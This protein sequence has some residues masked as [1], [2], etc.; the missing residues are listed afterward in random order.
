MQA[1][2]RI[3]ALVERSPEDEDVLWALCNAM[4]WPFRG[5]PYTMGGPDDDVQDRITAISP[6][7]VAAR[8][9]RAPRELVF[10]HRGLGGTYQIL[11]QL[12]ARADWGAMFEACMGVAK[13][14]LARQESA[15]GGAAPA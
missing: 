14:D 9:L 10:L 11:R 5:G 1:A 8:A 15:A 2:M 12:H 6:K 3:G 7:L 4:G 13:A